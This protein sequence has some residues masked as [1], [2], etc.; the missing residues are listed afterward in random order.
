MTATDTSDS[1]VTEQRND[2]SSLKGDQVCV[3]V[4]CA[5]WFRAGRSFSSS[6]KAPTVL[7]SHVTYM[8][9]ASAECQR[10]QLSAVS[11]V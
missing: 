3:C 8:S 4:P 10:D 2:H 11:S 1:T 5:P 9:R 6:V 7:S